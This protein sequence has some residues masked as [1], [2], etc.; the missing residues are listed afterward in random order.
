MAE[1][2]DKQPIEMKENTNSNYL[3]SEQRTDIINLNHSAKTALAAGNYTLAR[4]QALE[5]VE[6]S[7]VQS[8][9]NLTTASLDV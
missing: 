6:R 5:A 9:D 2:G 3:A 1:I 7:Q 8:T 4:D